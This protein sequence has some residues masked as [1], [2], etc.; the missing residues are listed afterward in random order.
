MIVVG[1]R[2]TLAARMVTRLGSRKR[3]EMYLPD[4]MVFGSSRGLI[5]AFM[6]TLIDCSMRPETE[7]SDW[8]TISTSNTRLID[9][10]SIMGTVGGYSIT[11]RL[12]LKAGVKSGIV[13]TKRD[14]YNVHITRSVD[15]YSLKYSRRKSYSGHV[16]EIDLFDGQIYVKNGRMPIWLD[17]K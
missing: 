16:Y 12:K 14:S 8:H 11:K 17:P 13:T 7:R 4:K 3:R 5:R 2:N 15:T 1:S 10:L 9:S 6:D